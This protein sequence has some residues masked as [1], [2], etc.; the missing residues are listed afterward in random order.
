MD[1]D[2]HLHKAFSHFDLDGNGFIDFEELKQTL[3][4]E[5]APE[6][7][8]LINDIINEVDTDKV[9][10]ILSHVCWLDELKGCF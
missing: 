7:T 9:E 6:V 10:H 8:E 1:D 2:D 5:L 3:M 4:D